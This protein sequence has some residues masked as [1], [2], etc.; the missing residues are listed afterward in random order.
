MGCCFWRIRGSAHPIHATIRNSRQSR[1]SA[2]G[3][4]SEQSTTTRG[5]EDSK[6]SRWASE[7]L[8]ILSRQ[9]LGTADKVER[10]PPETTTHANLLPPSRKPSQL[11]ENE[12]LVVAHSEVCVRD[13]SSATKGGGISF[14]SLPHTEQ[15]ADEG[16]DCQRIPNQGFRNGV[17][18]SGQAGSVT[19]SD[20]IR[21]PRTN[22]VCRRECDISQ[23]LG[24][25]RYFSPPSGPSRFS[26]LKSAEIKSR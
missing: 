5:R 17:L 4:A 6:S 13:I 26:D 1:A 18:H 8:S 12:H 23:H 7:D 25:G 22:R 3:I 24:T 15:E 19:P 10:V 20:S 2:W 21:I 16:E 11:G 14:L 9:L